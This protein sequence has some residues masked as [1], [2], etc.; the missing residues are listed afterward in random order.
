MQ[1]GKAFITLVALQVNIAAAEK[2]CFIRV[3]VLDKPWV[4]FY[5]EIDE[6]HSIVFPHGYY[7]LEVQKGCSPHRL[8]GSCDPEPFKIEGVST[9]SLPKDYK[10]D[11]RAAERDPA[12]KALIDKARGDAHHPDR[13]RLLWNSEREPSAE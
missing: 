6:T 4:G 1:L 5:A 7:R 3:S 11:Y 8:P 2:E 13:A 9:S 10:I 12:V